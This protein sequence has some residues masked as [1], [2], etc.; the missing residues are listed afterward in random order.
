VRDFPLEDRQLAAVV[1]VGI[2]V[3]AAQLRESGDV[4]VGDGA[5]LRH[6]RLS[7][8]ELL[9]VFLEGMLVAWKPLG[10]G[11]ELVEDPRQ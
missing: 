5:F 3:V 9:E 4:I 11:R 7:D 10:A 1:L 8:R 2:E 6:Q